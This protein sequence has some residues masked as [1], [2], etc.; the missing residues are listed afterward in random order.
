M[1]SFLISLLLTI[2]L[3]QSQV[4]SIVL[5]R[6]Q[7]EEWFPTTFNTTQTF[8]FDSLN[9]TSIDIDTFVSLSHLTSID[10][11]LNS[12]VEIDEQTFVS[13]TNLVYLDMSYNLLMNLS[14]KLLFKFKWE[15]LETNRVQCIYESCQTQILRFVS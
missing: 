4:N 11:S 15:Q 10:L 2:A 13:Q 12:L 6:K 14:S 7:L 1:N 8:D 5:N 9:I 3:K